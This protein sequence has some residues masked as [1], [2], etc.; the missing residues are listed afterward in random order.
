MVRASALRTAT[1]WAAAT[2]GLA[3]ATTTARTAD[4]T[5]TTTATGN[6]QLGDW[7]SGQSGWAGATDCTYAHI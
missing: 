1:A 2:A 6:E 4:N 7:A 5:A 3:N